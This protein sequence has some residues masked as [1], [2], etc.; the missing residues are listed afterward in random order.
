MSSARLSFEAR[1]N[2]QLQ[3][4]ANKE[5]RRH[6][7][8]SDGIDLSANDYLG[9]AGHPA[10]AQ[11]MQRALS[12]GVPVGATGSRL[13]SGHSKWH[14]AFEARMAAFAGTESAL[15]FNSGYDANVGALSTLF[16]AGDTIFADALIHASMIDGIRAA[17]AN[18]QPFRHNDL[19]HLEDLLRNGKSTGQRVIVVESVYSMDGDRAPLGDLAQLAERYNAMLFVDEAHGTGVFGEHGAGLL[20]EHGLC[21]LPVVTVHTFGKAWAAVGACVAASQSVCEV[22]IN[23]CRNFIYTTA[24]PPL[25]VVQL[26]KVLDLVEQADWRRA[27]VLALS[28]RLRNGLADVA[29][30]GAADS[31]IVPI[32]LGT[33]QAALAAAAGLQ[34]AGFAVRAIRPPT[35]PRGTARL[36][37]SL[38]ASLE[39]DD[40]DRLVKTCRRLFPMCQED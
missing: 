10:V 28:Q 20:A 30:M 2:A 22:L 19:N 40:L 39:D 38:S 4:L 33:D 32:V 24:L 11:A 17:K 9:L 23:R 26:D 13:L 25:T 18:W 21:G 12:E 34:K 1:L 16:G 6:L 37:L 5:R 14:A 31:P 27:R 7:Q 35:V 29:H 15:L 3:R 36:R 8:V